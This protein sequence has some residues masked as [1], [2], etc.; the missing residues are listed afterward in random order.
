MSDLMID[1]E[2]LGI[3]PNAMI[4]TIA[5]QAFDPFSEKFIGDPLYFR[6]DTEMQIGR[7]IEDSTLNW[8]NK[9]P[10]GQ[11]EAFAEDNR[12]ALS[13][14]LTQLSNM[15]WNKQRIWAQGISFDIPILENAYKQLEIPIPW[16]WWNVLDT[17]T[18]FRLNNEKLKNDHHALQD[19]VNQIILLQKTLKKLDITKL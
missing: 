18:M 14:A 4:L 15:V 13:T 2:T 16:K 12:V 7:S 10:E 9:H 1:I 5:A 17:R 11:A 6:I 19:C 3:T 8:W